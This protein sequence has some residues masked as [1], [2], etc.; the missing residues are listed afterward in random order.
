MPTNWYLFVVSYAVQ[1][2]YNV[3]INI[4]A[5]AGLFTEAEELFYS[6]RKKGCL[7]DSFTYLSLIR[8]YAQG[9][10]YG[11]GEKVITLMQKEGLPLS[12]AHF[13]V[14]LYSFAKEGLITE[15]E[16]VH[17]EITAAG[18][19]PDL[20]CNRTMLRCY[21][22]H[23]RVEEG[24][25]FFEKICETVEPDRFIMSVAIHMYKSVGMELK[26]E[27]LLKSMNNL[28]FQF[29]ENLVVGQR[30]KTP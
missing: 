29:I 25:S 8:A 23:G 2:S 6:M 22:D 28:R 21:M 12:C 27:A 30:V 16:R 9:L 3:M 5:A 7:P 11:E 26:A 14:L 18:L 24:I 15:V 19:T 20:E 17:K 1:V 10:N 4:Y 13:N